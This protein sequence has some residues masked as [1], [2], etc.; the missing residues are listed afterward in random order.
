MGV[1]D[2]SGMTAEL[3]GI[4]RNEAGLVSRLYNCVCAEE[5]ALIEER[6]DAI[7]RA[8]ESQEELAAGFAD[9]EQKRQAKV[10]ELS[11]KMGLKSETPLLREIAEKLTD[12]GPARCLRDAGKRLS[13]AMEKLRRKNQ[14][15]RGILSLR[16]EYTETLLNLI[17]GVEDAPGRNYG[18]R[19]Q[20][21]NTEDP[22]PGMYEV[23]I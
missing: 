12:A 23:T 14:T 9:L 8:V 11:E 7:Q 13:A 15:V 21:L 18:A 22:G 16:G 6:L 10:R 1:Q 20:I 17:A 2:V 19:G 3:E 4:L 5:N